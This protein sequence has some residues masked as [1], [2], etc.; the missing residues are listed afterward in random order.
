MGFYSAGV[1]MHSEMKRWTGREGH[2]DLY[3]S[4]VRD[5]EEDE[6]QI[7]RFPYQGA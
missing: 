3:E 7:L 1:F 5:A 2:N 6:E 4:M